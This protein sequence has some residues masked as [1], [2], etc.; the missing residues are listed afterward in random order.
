MVKEISFNDQSGVLLQHRQINQPIRS[1]VTNTDTSTGQ[2][3]VL[4]Q[5]QGYTKQ[6][7]NF[8][9]AGQWNVSLH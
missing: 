8:S 4:T 6:S 5:T 9:Q 1:F 2:S 3:H 7:W